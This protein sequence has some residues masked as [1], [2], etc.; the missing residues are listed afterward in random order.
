LFLFI[1]VFLNQA[2]PIRGAVHFHHGDQPVHLET[3]QAQSRGL[4]GII[5]VVTPHNSVK[6]PEVAS[7]VA[8]LTIG[9]ETVRIWREEGLNNNNPTSRLNNQTVHNVQKDEYIFSNCSI[10]NNVYEQFTEY[11]FEYEQGSK[12]ILVKNRLR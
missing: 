7:H 2:L 12:H 10:H 4:D 3:F 6:G 8:S 5:F 1:P 9:G 11:Y